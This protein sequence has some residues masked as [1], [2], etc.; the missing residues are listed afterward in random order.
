ML[1]KKFCI[2]SNGLVG[3]ELAKHVRKGDHSFDFRFCRVA[4][5][6]GVGCSSIALIRA[7]NVNRL[8]EHKLG[9]GYQSN[10]FDDAQ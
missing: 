10:F 9:V 7:W 2:H 4:Y 1:K 6:S 8:D 3:E 5:L